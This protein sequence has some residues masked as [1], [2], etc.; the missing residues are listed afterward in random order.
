VSERQEKSVW[1]P[2]FRVP[3]PTA[4]HPDKAKRFRL[5]DGW[6]N[7]AARDAVLHEIILGDW[8]VAVVIAAMVSMLDFNAVDDTTSRERQYFPCRA[9]EHFD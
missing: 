9:F 6:R 3:A 2:V 8:Q 4:L 5:S 1:L 7:E